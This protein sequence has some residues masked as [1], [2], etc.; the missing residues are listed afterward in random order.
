VIIFAIDDETAM[1]AELH[2][3]IAEAEPNAEIHDFQYAKDVLSAISEKKIL[4]DVVFSDIELPGMDGLSLAV[5]IKRTAPETKIVF[6]TGYSQYAV[7]AFRRR[8]NGYLLKPVDAGQIREELDYLQEYYKPNPEKLQVKCFG[9]FEVY[10]QGKALAFERKQSKELFAFLIDRNSIC[11]A[12]DIADALW[13]GD[14]DMAAC[15]T[16]IRSLLHDLKNTFSSIGL[17]DI[18][19]RKRDRIGIETDRIECDYYRFLMGDVQ[20]VNAFHGEYM[21]QYSWAEPTMGKLVFREE[22]SGALPVRR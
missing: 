19:I 10:W 7:E 12:E 14:P 13:E 3:A 6:V 11:A 1:L 21:S 8:I 15:K 5:Q 2:D 18:L 4:P 9:F 22:N 20:A 17:N 16:R